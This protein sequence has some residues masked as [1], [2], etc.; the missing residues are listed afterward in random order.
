MRI[1]K[2]AFESRYA[3]QSRCR[4][5]EDRERDRE[6]EEA[7]VTMPEMTKELENWL[8]DLKK[9]IKQHKERYILCPKCI[10]K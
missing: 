10:A 3:S 6:V 9:D 8:K 1:P 7:S 5:P 2:S 4:T